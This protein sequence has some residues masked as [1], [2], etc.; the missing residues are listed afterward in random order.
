MPNDSF[1]IVPSN[2]II[3]SEM[4]E[5]KHRITSKHLGCDVI[6]ACYRNGFNPLHRISF[7]Q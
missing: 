6:V 4:S 3:K 5:P 2:R 1:G 7:I